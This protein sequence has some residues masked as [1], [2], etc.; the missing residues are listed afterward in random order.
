MRIIN[1]S[2]TLAKHNNLCRPPHQPL[3]R[4]LTKYVLTSKYLFLTHT[5]THTRDRTSFIPSETCYSYYESFRRWVHSNQSTALK[6]DPRWT[7]EPR[8]NMYDMVCAHTVA[9]RTTFR[10]H[11]APTADR[12]IYNIV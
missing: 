10:F 3:T 8:Y 6:T 5:H 4:R 1:L 2:R 12:R 11:L 9:G 7:D